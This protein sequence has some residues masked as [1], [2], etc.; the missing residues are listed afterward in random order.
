MSGVAGAH[1]GPLGAPPGGGALVT[2]PP[3]PDIPPP[4]LTYVLA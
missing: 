3:A 2:L 1:T 4:N